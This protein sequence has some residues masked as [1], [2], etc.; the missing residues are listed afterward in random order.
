QV[1]MSFTGSP[2]RVR[3]LRGI[4]QRGEL[5]VELSVTVPDER[6]HESRYYETL[7]VETTDVHAPPG[8]TPM[9]VEGRN[10]VPV[11]L[12]RLIER[13]LPVRYD[14]S[15]ADRIGPVH[16]EPDTVLVKGPQEVLDKA[17]F[18]PTQ[19]WVLPSRP[20][21]SGLSDAAQARVPLVQELD[22]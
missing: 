14:H 3:E 2:A 10:R 19:P 17:T 18:I 16:V 20:P 22:G 7:H 6:L 8:V 12:H 5:H 21:G 15:L 11:V 4:L 9:I 13:R 1:L